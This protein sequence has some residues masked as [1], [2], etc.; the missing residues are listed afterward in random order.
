MIL[1]VV[2][3]QKQI[4]NAGLYKFDLFV[5]NVKKLIST[6]RKNN[7]EIIYVRHDDGDGSDLTKG[8]DGFEIFEEFSPLN[9]EKIFDKTVNSSFNNTGLLEYLNEKHEKSIIVVGLQTDFCIDA[10]VK[11]GFEHGFEILIPQYA[12]STFDNQYMSAEQ[13]YEYYNNYI[14]SKRY[15]KCLSVNEVLDLMNRYSLN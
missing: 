5:D 8:S 14:W 4:T 7:I 2:D 3:T 11:C 6:A 10:T 13:T 15:A 12:N 1:L 9:D